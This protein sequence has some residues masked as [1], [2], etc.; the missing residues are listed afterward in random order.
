MLTS[1]HAVGLVAILITAGTYALI[2]LM[3]ARSGRSQRW[4]HEVWIAFLALVVAQGLVGVAIAVTKA[5]PAEAIHWV[6]GGA[7]LLIL[8]IGNGLALSTLGGKRGQVMTVTAALVAVL[9]WRLS[10]T[11]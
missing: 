1:L 9:A 11:G 5:G 8:L 6:Y 4:S 10:Q 3:T 2:G 7:I